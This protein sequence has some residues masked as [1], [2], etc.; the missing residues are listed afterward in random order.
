MALP[1]VSQLKRELRPC[2]CL[3]CYLGPSPSPWIPSKPGPPHS[4][5]KLTSHPQ[6][7]VALW[8]FRDPG[9][10]HTSCMSSGWSLSHSPGRSLHSEDVLWPYPQSDLFLPCH[11]PQAQPISPVGSPTP[12][13]FPR[14]PATPTAC[15]LQGPHLHSASSARGHRHPGR[16]TTQLVQAVPLSCTPLLGA[17]RE[18]LSCWLRAAAPRLAAHL[19]HLLGVSHVLKTIRGSVSPMFPAAVA[20]KG[21]RAQDQAQ[22]IGQPEMEAS[23]RRKNRETGVL[24]GVASSLLANV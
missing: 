1:Q 19:N 23:R 17:L 7:T 10:A 9:T 6:R 14:S 8:G 16:H 4:L 3:T 21:P 5:Q 24:W 12:L 15:L 2:W 20:K 11:I 13:G 22:R 18:V